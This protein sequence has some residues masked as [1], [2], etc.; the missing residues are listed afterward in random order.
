MTNEFA[1]QL[2]GNDGCYVLHGL[3]VRAAPGCHDLPGSLEAEAEKGIRTPLDG[4][5]G[6]KVVL[7]C[8]GARLHP[9]VKSL[10]IAEVEPA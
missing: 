8:C 5:H 4:Q 6:L 7:S 9:F 2:V 1:M 3:R 10:P